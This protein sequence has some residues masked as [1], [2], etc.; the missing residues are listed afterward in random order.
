MRAIRH[1]EG[2]DSQG[3]L[4]KPIQNENMLWSVSIQPS[5]LNQILGY[6]LFSG[7]SQSRY[8]YPSYGFL[9]TMTPNCIRICSYHLELAFLPLEY[10]EP[11][12]ILDNH[13]HDMFVVKVHAHEIVVLKV[14]G[15]AITVMHA[16]EG[17]CKLLGAVTHTVYYM[18]DFTKV[19]P[20]ATPGASCEAQ[21]LASTPGRGHTRTGSEMVCETTAR[22]N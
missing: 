5:G 11:R 14:H 18:C 22:L 2:S 15:H 9:Q 6:I 12:V 4:H 10:H 3:V 19:R 21:N 13:G 16:H 17:R 20:A 7:P 8:L 1:L